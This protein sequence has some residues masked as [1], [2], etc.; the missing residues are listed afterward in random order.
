MIGIEA[1]EL[2]RV[3]GIEPLSI[4]NWRSPVGNLFSRIENSYKSPAIQERAI[5]GTIVMLLENPTP[6]GLRKSSPTY[7]GR[8]RTR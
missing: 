2:E 8:T 4:L 7:Q 5:D 6:D 3:E 1:G